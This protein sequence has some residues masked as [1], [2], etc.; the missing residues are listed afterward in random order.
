MTDISVMSRFKSSSNNQ[1]ILTGLITTNSTPDDPSTTSSA[2]SKLHRWRIF[3][4]HY[5]LSLPIH[6]NA[7]LEQIAGEVN[8]L[9][10]PLA[11]PDST[12]LS[13]QDL[14]DFKSD[15]EDIIGKAARLDKSLRLSKAYFHVQLS[16]DNNP[17]STSLQFDSDIM[18]MVQHVPGFQQDE[19][20]V[21]DFVVS[22]GIFKTGNADGQNYDKP[23]TIFA[24][25]GVLCNL[26]LRSK[27]TR[28]LVPERVQDAGTNVERSVSLDQYDGSKV[29]EDEERIKDEDNVEGKGSENREHSDGDNDIEEKEEEEEEG[30]E[31]EEEEEE[32]EGDEEEGDEDGE[33]SE[34]ERE[35][36]DPRQRDRRDLI[37]YP[38]AVPVCL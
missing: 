29:G 16:P 17:S 10:I 11:F 34:A 12:H 18:N 15:L 35:E 27:E 33:L 22:P 2:L 9:L 14:E 4:T 36:W 32:E 23:P 38:T 6:N 31:E 8:K 28:D 5:F 37:R 7:E 30:E 1:L 26:P 20:L 24:K 3:S 13:K 25:F 19:K 21:V